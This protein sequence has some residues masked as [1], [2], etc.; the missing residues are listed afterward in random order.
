MFRNTS[1]VAQRYQLEPSYNVL[2]HPHPTLAIV[3]IYLD[4][5]W[6]IYGG[7]QLRPGMCVHGITHLATTNCWLVT[8]ALGG[9]LISWA[10]AV[11]SGHKLLCFTLVSHVALHR[12]LNTTTSNADRDERMNIWTC[13]VM[14]STDYVVL[15][16]FIEELMSVI[17]KTQGTVCWP[18]VKQAFYWNLLKS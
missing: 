10:A 3:Q 4:H 15:T 5:L 9:P 8:R 11:L 6:P 13:R 18:K 2:F 1:L 12:K 7:G 17:I 16:L 14:R